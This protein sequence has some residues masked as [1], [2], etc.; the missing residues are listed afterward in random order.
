[1]IYDLSNES[2]RKKFSEQARTLLADEAVIEIKKKSFTRSLSQNA[3]LHLLLGYFATQ[4]G[5]SRDE[6]KVDY[7]KRTCN[8]DL[9]ERSRSNRFGANVTYLR[10]SRDLTKEEMSLSIDRFRDWAS[11][12]AGIYLPSADD[13]RMIVFAMSEVD[14][15]KEYL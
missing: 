12:N 8:R 6:A 15:A 11:A 4:Y 10:S 3:F 13:H 7:Y 2:H 14:R 1:M 9:F 5:C